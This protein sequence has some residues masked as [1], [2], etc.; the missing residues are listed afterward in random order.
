[1]AFQRVVEVTVGPKGGEG[2]K[3][4]GL[5]IAFS[6]EKTDSPDTN[7]S[8]IQIYNLSKDTH[9]KAA[10]AGNHITLKAGYTDETVTAIFFG[11]VLKGERKK[12]GTDFITEL[13][14]Y[15]SR[16]AVMAGQVSVSYAK[17]TGSR[18]I[19]QAFLDAI[20]KPYKGLENVPE[21][22]TYPHGFAFI[23]MA[24]D[25]LMDVLNRYGLAYTV[26]NEMIYIIKPGEAADKTGLKLTA[27]TGLLTTPEPV[28]DKTSDDDAEAEAGNRWKFSSLLFPELLP[29]AACK[30]ESSTL[31]GEVVIKKAILAGDNWGGDFKI[32]IEAAAV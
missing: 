1:M 20:G 8:K 27:R 13:E 32:D 10:V 28:S 9:A 3:I 24:G 18:T 16:T 5:K 4:T 21:G 26:Q 29:G 6:I 7:K 25:G 14:V 12:S 15:D 23:G 31:D 22:E 17:D 2:F 19:V 30:V 11:D